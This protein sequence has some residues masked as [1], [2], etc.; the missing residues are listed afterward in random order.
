MMMSEMNRIND[1]VYWFTSK[2]WGLVRHDIMVFFRVEFELVSG[3]SK[4]EM[5]LNDELEVN[6]DG[7]K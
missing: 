6:N 1:V 2:F 5:L 7:D 4:C 3:I